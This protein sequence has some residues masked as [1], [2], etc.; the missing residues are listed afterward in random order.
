MILGAGVFLI[1]VTRKGPRWS[2]SNTQLRT[3]NRLFAVFWI[4][5]LSGG[6]A[7]G[8]PQA[9]DDMAAIVRLIVRIVGFL[10]PIIAVAILR[11]Q[12]PG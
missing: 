3:V 11:N 9:E 2:S 6:E 7:S 8:R 1:I 12:Q 5:S 4:D 10:A